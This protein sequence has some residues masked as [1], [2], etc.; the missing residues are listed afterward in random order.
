MIHIILYDISSD[1]IRNKIAR[2]LIAEGYE[3]I[4]LSVFAGNSHPKSNKKLWQS[5]KTWITQEPDAK[6]FVLK[7]PASNFKE[8]T[9]L[10]K[11]GLDLDFLLG[12][13]NSIFI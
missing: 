13:K 1:S 9:I 12:L 10:G 3:R 6:F 4:Q 7:V 2:R 11:K 8:M 5:F